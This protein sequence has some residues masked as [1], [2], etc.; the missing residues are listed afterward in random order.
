VKRQ[1]VASRPRTWG[2]TWASEEMPPT[3]MPPVVLTKTLAGAD[4]VTLSLR[5]PAKPPRPVPPAA[6]PSGPKQ[7][8]KA[9]A[10]AAA[11]AVVAPVVAW[12]IAASLVLGPDRALEG[13]SQALALLPGLPGV[14]L[15]RAFLAGVLARCDRSAQVSFG[16]LFSQAE[17]EIGENVYVGPGCFLGLVR[18]EKD[19][20]IGAGVHIP[21]G[22]KTHSFDD[23]T[24]PI[25]EQGGERRRV[26]V[27][28]GAWVGS[29]AVVLADVGPGTVVGAGSVVTRPLPANVIAA[30]N[31]A[32]VIRPRFPSATDGGC[33]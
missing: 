19:V 24:R 29:A 10:H 14:Y 15:R 11:T 13:T 17:A 16:T 2:T 20:L 23:P 4:A 26:T 28:E 21:S 30:G 5:P 3:P 8:A 9:A 1:L 7:V 18:L 33:H 25:R 12:Y 22:G 27:G 6:G 32:R 31:P